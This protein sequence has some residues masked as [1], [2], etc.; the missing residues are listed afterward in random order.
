MVN[1]THLPDYVGIVRHKK[2]LRIFIYVSNFFP[3]IISK[4]TIP[5]PQMHKY[6][7]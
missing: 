2:S 3:N 7:R 4:M 1:T 6:D 5:R